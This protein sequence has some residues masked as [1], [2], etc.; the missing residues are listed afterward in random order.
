MATKLAITASIAAA[1]EI[2]IAASSPAPGIP[3][4]V[5]AG[6]TISAEHL[7]LALV[8]RRHDLGTGGTRWAAMSNGVRD[9][10]CRWLYAGS[11]YRLPHAPLLSPMDR[12]HIT[13]VIDRVRSQGRDEVRRTFGCGIRA[14]MASVPSSVLKVGQ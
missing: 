12:G 11:G 14:L 4:A 13:R 1:Q 6:R 7:R 8:A 2:G 5:D 10:G 9:Q 3:S